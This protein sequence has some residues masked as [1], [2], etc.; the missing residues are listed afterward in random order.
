MIEIK[1]AII[2][3]TFLGIEDHGVF[4]AIISLNYGGSEQGFGQHDLTYKAY[5][6]TYLRKI[7]ETVGVDSWEELV[8][9]P[10]RSKCEHTKVHAIG[11]LI[12]DKWF[13]PEKD[14]CQ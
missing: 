8:G 13:E 7:L 2:K 12:E 11:H 10:I 6:I 5:G 3:K 1:N 14:L 9:K 4:T